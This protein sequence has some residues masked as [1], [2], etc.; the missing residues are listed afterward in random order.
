MKSLGVLQGTIVD[1]E[2]IWGDLLKKIRKKL[3]GWKGRG[4]SF[5]GKSYLIKSIAMGTIA[6]QAEF[7]EITEKALKSIKTCI[8]EFFWENKRD[9]IAR[10]VCRG[11]KKLGGIGMVDVEAFIEARYVKNLE[12][13][14]R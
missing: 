8:W 4:L 6:Y 7:V 12:K 2:K 14:T 11:E 13:I 3:D 5:T 9:L 10:N 1:K